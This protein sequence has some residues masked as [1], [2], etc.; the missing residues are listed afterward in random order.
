MNTNFIPKL[1]VTLALL[2]AIVPLHAQTTDAAKASNEASQSAE[3][4]KKNKADVYTEALNLNQEQQTQVREIL[5]VG[6]NDYKT[7][8]AD[9]TIEPKQKSQKLKAIKDGYNA[10]VRALLTPEQAAKFDEM[11]QKPAKKAEGKKGGKDD[12]KE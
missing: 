11:N 4:K 7:L 6:W 8:K 10:K 1:A 9:E 12:D 2:S 5:K 3:P